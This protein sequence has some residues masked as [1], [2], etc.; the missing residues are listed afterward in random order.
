MK[1]KLIIESAGDD[2][3][4]S[5]WEYEGEDDELVVFLAE[6]IEGFLVNLDAVAEELEHVSPN[7]LN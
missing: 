4:T 7:K 6:L 2:T 5:R 3:I 1:A